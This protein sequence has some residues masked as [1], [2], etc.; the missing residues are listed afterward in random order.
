MLYIIQFVAKRLV[1]VNV[2]YKSELC[3]VVYILFYFY[4]DAYLSSY[5]SLFISGELLL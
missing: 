2:I 3:I 5:F 1:L 4:I